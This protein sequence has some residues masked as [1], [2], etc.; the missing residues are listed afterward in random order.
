MR[1][2][3]RCVL[4]YVG[5][6]LLPVVAGGQT[7]VINGTQLYAG[8]ANYGTTAG[9]ATAYTLTFAPALAGY[10]AGQC[11]LMKPHVANTGPA[12]LNVQDKGALTIS[13]ASGETLV[14]LVAGDLPSG[15]LMQVC[16]DG[17]ILQ[18]MGAVPDAAIRALSG[19]A[20]GSR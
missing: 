3:F 9:T 12:T 11:F 13:K 19:R 15:R 6:C 18:L 1:R 8:W 17:T 16:Y 7:T 5:L 14:P 2:S 10:V 4:L 20:P